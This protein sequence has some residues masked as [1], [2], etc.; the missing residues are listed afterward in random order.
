MKPFLKQGITIF[1][2]SGLFFATFMALMDYFQGYEFGA[3]KF[4]FSALFFG[5]IQA[6]WRLY[7]MY[8]N[9][10]KFNIDVPN[11]IDFKKIQKEEITTN[12]RPEELRS[13]IDKNYV[14]LNIAKFQF[15][16]NRVILRT[17]GDGVSP[18]ETI[19]IDILPL[20]D[21]KYSYTIENKSNYKLPIHDYGKNYVQVKYLIRML[22]KPESKLKVA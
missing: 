16:E 2:F 20:E 15:E 4:F 11:K 10:K 3:W 5:G 13:L 18:S 1:L 21:E 6:G 12:T 19:T 22:Q 8:Q 17:K 9:F 7:Y 14:N